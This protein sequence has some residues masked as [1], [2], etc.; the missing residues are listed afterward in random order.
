MKKLI[1]ILFFLILATQLIP[2]EHVA[3]NLWSQ[4]TAE[5]EVTPQTL[6]KGLQPVLNKLWYLDFADDIDQFD[7]KNSHSFL[8]VDEALIKCYHLEVLIQPPDFI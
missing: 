5:E 6:V 2:A 1:S 7:T 3:K 4:T 8:I